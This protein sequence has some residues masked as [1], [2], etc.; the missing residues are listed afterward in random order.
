MRQVLYKYIRD[1]LCR[2]LNLC[3]LMLEEALCLGGDFLVA[4]KVIVGIVFSLRECPVESL[5]E[6]C[7]KE[8]DRSAVTDQMMH[9]GQKD[10]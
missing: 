10:C 3:H 9:V 2:F 1:Q 6:L 7:D 5:G 4:H 8:I